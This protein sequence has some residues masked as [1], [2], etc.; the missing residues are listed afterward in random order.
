MRSVSG[1]ALEAMMVFTPRV[2]LIDEDDD[3][4]AT[5]ARMLP[6]ERYTCDTAPNA[7]AG[8]ERLRLIT[9]DVVIA[10]VHMTDMDGL[11]LLQWIKRERPMLPVLLVS[12]NGAVGEAVEAMKLGAFH[13]LA[14]PCV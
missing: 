13:Y 4:R 9:F 12:T 1:K 8:I 6:Q 3:M 5:L 7:L 10:E 14:K 11:A 2:L